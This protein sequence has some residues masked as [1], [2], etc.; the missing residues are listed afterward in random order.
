MAC[1][2][3]V[4]SSNAGGISEVN[5]HGVTGFVSEIGDIDDMVS[6]TLKILTDEVLLTQ[7]KANALARAKDFSLEKIL[8]MYERYYEKIVGQSWKF[9]TQKF[10]DAE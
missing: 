8:P 9:P 6:N 1:E 10:T 5:I 7:M 3:P 4:I 2:V